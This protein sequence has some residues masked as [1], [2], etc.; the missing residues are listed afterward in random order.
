LAARVGLIASAAAGLLALG[1]VLGL[2]RFSFWTDEAITGLSIR[3]NL[4]G[5]LAILRTGDGSSSAQPLFYFILWFW[6]RLAGDSEAV[7]RVPSLLYWA[8]G[9]VALWWVLRLLG[10]SRTSAWTGGVSFL[11]LPVA[12]WYA[13]EAR[14]YSLI[15]LCVAL[16]MGEALRCLRAP[17][18]RLWR[19]GLA[20]LVVVLAY[21]V[22]GVAALG[23]FWVVLGWTMLNRPAGA[24]RPPA[25]LAGAV[26]LFTTVGTVLVIL[27]S[28]TRSSGIRAPTG[29][30]AF[31]SLGYALYELALG[32]T[33]GFS[34]VELRQA[35]GLAGLPRLVLAHPEQLLIVL[36]AL[37]GLGYVAFQGLRLLRLRG[38]AEVLLV[39]LPWL[40]AVAAFCTYAIYPGFLMNGRHIVFGLPPLAVLVMFGLSR[41]PRATKLAA[42]TIVWAL[43]AVAFLGFAFDERYAKEDFR[44]AA[45]IVSSCQLRPE[46]TFLDHFPP[47]FQYYG[48]AGRYGPV[49][50]GLAFLRA[51][52]GEPAV[53]IVDTS[54]FDADGLVAAAQR[55]PD[56]F[57]RVD[58]PS[59]T[60]LSTVPLDGCSPR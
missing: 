25:R 49:E 12:I 50:D 41:T 26:A 7:L 43:G 15:M 53:L 60:L 35:E 39:T 29:L 11:A 34:V 16:H 30:K 47:G 6:D 42:L 57:Y 9:A 4:G 13:L 28:L 58:L 27:S 17:T 37:A 55:R 2:N 31:D 3:E 5:L 8:A 22:A 19:L 36:A 21:S 20:T 40:A 10:L 18:P 52:R 32:R 14:P 23:A 56:A 46:N 1:L 59:L 54:R 38:D 44:S 48:V 45:R 24:G 33:V 51:R